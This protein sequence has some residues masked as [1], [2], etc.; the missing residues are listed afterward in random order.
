MISL[1]VLANKV[2]KRGLKNA[3]LV[4]ENCNLSSNSPWNFL[5]EVGGTML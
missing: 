2:F 1:S 3:V 5:S 4:R